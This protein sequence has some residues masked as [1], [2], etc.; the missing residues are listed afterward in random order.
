MMG[1][2]AGD[3]SSYHDGITRRAYYQMHGACP[4]RRDATTRAWGCGR[5]ALHWDPL[6]HQH[7]AGVAAWRH[8]YMH[9]TCTHR[10]GDIVI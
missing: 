5:A 2:S 3:P 4:W 7:G 9:A 10:A 6:P 1:G 8:M